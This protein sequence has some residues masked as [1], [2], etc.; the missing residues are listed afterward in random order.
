V[1]ILNAL[2]RGLPVVATSDAAEGLELDAG[3][4]LL[5]VDDPRSAAT[6]VAEV[7]R[8]D[9]RWTSLSERGRAAIRERYRPNVAFAELDRAL[10]GDGD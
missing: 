7:L 4:D 9:D 5:V 2:A 3:R 10:G 6:A 1:K 8:D